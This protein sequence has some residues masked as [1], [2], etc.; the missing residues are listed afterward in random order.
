MSV[1]GFDQQA[2]A[3]DLE[4]TPFHVAHVFDDVN[5]VYWAH[6]QMLK[7]FVNEHAPLKSRTPLRLITP[8]R[9]RKLRKAIYKKRMFYNRFFKQRS[10]RNWEYGVPSLS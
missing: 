4:R 6:E 10:D 2:F 8:F 1:R 3:D 9:N 7:Q 5:D